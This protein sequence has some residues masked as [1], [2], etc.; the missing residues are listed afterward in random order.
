MGMTSENN[1]TSYLF[2]R[3]TKKIN[4]KG[5]VPIYCR[6]TFM[7]KRSEFCTGI[8]VEPHFFSDGKII[9]ENN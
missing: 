7:G 1:F 9:V 8:L 5:V 3:S 6:I 2:Y 4:K